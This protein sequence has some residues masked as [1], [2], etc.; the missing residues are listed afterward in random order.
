MQTPWNGFR[1]LREATSASAMGQLERGTTAADTDA[2]EVDGANSSDG[3]DSV[4]VTDCPNCDNGIKDDG[5]VCPTCDGAGFTGIREAVLTTAA[6]K[7]IPRSSYAIPSKAPGSGSYPIPD[8]AHARN[9]LARVSGKPEEATV[10]AAVYKKFPQL[11]PGSTSESDRTSLLAAE[12]VRLREGR[13]DVLATTHGPVERAKTSDGRDGFLMDLIQEGKGSTGFYTPDVLKEFVESKRGEGMQAYA[14]HPTLDMEEK[15]PERSV[16]DLVGSHHDLRIAESGGKAVIKSIFVPIKGPG[17]EWVNTLAETASQHPGP[18]PLAG[19]SLYGESDGEYTEL[20]DGTFGWLPK[21]LMPMSGDIVT[22]AGAGG[23]FVREL[24]ESVRRQ[25]LSATT[26]TPNTG[27]K[28]MK[29][30]EFKSKLREAHGKLAQADTDE[31]RAA[32]LTELDELANAEIETPEPTVE[33]VS[34]AL[35]ESLR[36]S[37]KAEVA[38]DTEGLR[39]QNRDLLVKVGLITQDQDA[40]RVVRE[41]EIVEADQEWFVTEIK[42]RNL[43]EADA[44]KQFVEAQVARDQRI[45]ESFLAETTGVEGNP[46]R[47][48]A[49]AS[50]DKGA[51]VLRE[52]GVPLVKQAA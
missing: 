42:T 35:V 17:Y 39:E 5:T 8:L 14:D 25:L 10:K 29:P 40:R 16:R 12:A 38:K 13:K 9:A 20:P 48:P 32:A 37:V 50:G 30:D 46:G 22:N 44:M 21:K 52:A 2:D 24:L 33:T 41:A 7:R 11:K 26:T 45:R 23:G 47:T 43:R 51:S 34:P 6:R 15:L 49:N 1:R 27:D 3:D 18:K 19:V 36:E 28:R 31:K 4:E